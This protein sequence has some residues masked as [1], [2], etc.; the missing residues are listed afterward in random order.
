MNGRELL[1]LMR[2]TAREMMRTCGHRPNVA[3]LP[4]R[5]E[6]AIREA[7]AE[8][9]N[10]DPADVQPTDLGMGLMKWG[11]FDG[12]MIYTHRMPKI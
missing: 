8:A 7:F 11:T 1:D 4:E 5:A 9:L 12:I 10:I 2:E 3:D 6:P